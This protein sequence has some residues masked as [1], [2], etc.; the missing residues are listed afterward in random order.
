MWTQQAEDSQRH[1]RSQTS[2]GEW[3]WLLCSTAATAQV[4]RQALLAGLRPIGYIK[5]ASQVLWCIA[6][7]GPT[8][9]VVA[10]WGGVPGVRMPYVARSHRTVAS[11]LL[12]VVRCDQT[13]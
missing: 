12:I 2:N 7:L 3:T 1:S 4:A 13:H 10:G 11:G 6:G 8:G 9:H 5:H